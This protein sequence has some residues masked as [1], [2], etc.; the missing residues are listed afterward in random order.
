MDILLENGLSD[1][2]CYYHSNIYQIILEAIIDTV[3]FIKSTGMP[4]VSSMP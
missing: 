1:I 4:A 2:R 3:M